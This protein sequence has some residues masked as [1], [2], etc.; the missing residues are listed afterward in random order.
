MRFST[1]RSISLRVFQSRCLR[2]NSASA[3]G[4]RQFF[5]LLL[6]TPCKAANSRACYPDPVARFPWPCA[7]FRGN[8]GALRPYLLCDLPATCSFSFPRFESSSSCSRAPSPAPP[9]PCP[10]ASFCSYSWRMAS[11]SRQRP[12]SLISVLHDGQMM[13]FSHARSLAHFRSFLPAPCQPCRVPPPSRAA[14]P[15]LLFARANDRLESMNTGSFRDPPGT[16]RRRSGRCT[17]GVPY[18]PRG[19]QSCVIVMIDVQVT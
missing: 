13:S 15:I 6:H 10:A 11:K 5:I 2:R 3:L 14:L 19:K 12:V 16:V 4:R 7:L 8:D 9:C 18:K 1:F 17:V